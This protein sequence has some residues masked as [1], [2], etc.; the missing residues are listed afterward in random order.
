METLILSVQDI[1]KIIQT[2]SLDV[3]M[4]ETITQLSKA[5]QEFDPHKTTIPVRSGFN[6]QNPHLGLIEWM[7]LLHQ[8]EQVV[9]KV[10]GYHP[11]NPKIRN[12]PTILSTVSAYDTNSGHLIG[13]MDSTFLTAVRTGAASAVASKL[14]AKSESKTLG[15]IGCGAQAVSQLHGL[16]RIFDLEQVLL[17]D[18][19]SLTT[20]SYHDRISCLDLKNLT[21]KSAS[22]EELVTQADIIC[23]ATSVDV[24]NLLLSSGK[25]PTSESHIGRR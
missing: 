25:T 1:H 13:L 9:I 16:S 22:L 19:D 10:V 6:Y 7:P 15:L 20:S 18:I 17:Y 11:T 24:G 5:F 23:T 2:I 12:L 4:D 8:E 14:M 3:F 21:I